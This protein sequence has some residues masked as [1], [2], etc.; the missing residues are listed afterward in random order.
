MNNISTIKDKNPLKRNLLT[1][2]IKKRK[3]PKFLRSRNCW[4]VFSGKW[5]QSSNKIVYLNE[6]KVKTGENLSIIG[7]SNWRNLI[8]EVRF[9]LLT[10]SIHPPE[11]GVIFYFLFQNIKNYYSFHF[12][13]EK[14]KIE[15]I[16]R[17]KGVWITI[18]EQDYNLETNK[19]YQISIDSNS[20]THQCRVNKANPL[21][22]HDMDVTKGC[23]GIGIKYCNAEFSHFSIST[24]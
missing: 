10:N 7:S 18:A 1:A 14:K 12:C 3:R 9:K 24:R 6:P 4:E 23:I 19:D 21:I 16:K 8:F 17:I 2:P 5:M 13:L 11:G 15:C 22:V 20:G